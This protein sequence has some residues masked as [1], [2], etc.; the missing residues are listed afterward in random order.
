MFQEGSGQLSLSDGQASCKDWWRVSSIRVLKGLKNGG[1]FIGTPEPG[2][3]GSP[4]RSCIFEGDHDTPG[5]ILGGGCLP[6]FFKTWSLGMTIV[7]RPGGGVPSSS[8]QEGLVYLQPLLYQKLSGDWGQGGFPEQEE[9]LMLGRG[10][11]WAFQSSSAS[12]LGQLWRLGV[13]L[14]SLPAR[15][16]TIPPLPNS[17]QG[18]KLRAHSS[19]NQLCRDSLIAVPYSIPAVV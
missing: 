16:F 3:E 7:W 15:I 1:F 12:A 2:L 8:N 17:A 4:Q 13:S 10:S 18:L 11:H 5:S 14:L 9:P 6:C 19:S